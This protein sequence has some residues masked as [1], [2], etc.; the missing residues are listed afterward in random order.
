M[1]FSKATQL[2]GGI[3]IL[4]VSLPSL[5]FVF[6]FVLLWLDHCNT[7]SFSKDRK[8][9]LVS[10]A[11]LPPSLVTVSPQGAKPV[12]AGKTTEATQ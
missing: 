6:D 8:A 3:Q 9:A 7:G 11:I 12:A 4:G 1:L 10:T 2:A 5:G